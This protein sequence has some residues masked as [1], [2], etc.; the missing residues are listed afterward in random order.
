MGTMKLKCL[1]CGEE[2]AGFKLS[3]DHSCDS[4][5]RSQ[6]QKKCFEPGSDNSIFK[7]IDWLPIES[8]LET[9]IGPIV[10]KSEKFSKKLD[11]A[12]LYIAFNGYWPEKG[13]GNMTGTFKDFEALP[14]LIYFLENGKKSIILSSA[15]NTARAFAYAATLLDIDTYIVIPDR[16]LH[17]I[18][19]PSDADSNR[20]HII[21]LKES[22]DYYQ[23]I[24]LSNRISRELN[25]ESEGG[26]K[27][28]ARRDGLGTVILEAARVIDKLPDHYF[29]AVGSGTGGIAA[30]EAS[31]RLLQNEKFA[32]QKIPKLNLVQNAPFAPIYSAW[33]EGVKVQPEQNVEEQLLKIS[34]MY[35]DVLA[36]RNPIFYPRGGVYDVLNQTDGK[37]YAVNNQEAIEA[38]KEFEALE[39]VD[40]DPGAS[41]C[42]AALIK[43]VK[44]KIVRKDET[45]LLNITGGGFKKIKRDYHCNSIEPEVIID[46]CSNLKLETLIYKTI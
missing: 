6:Y 44:N 26:A 27:N 41:V 34:K 37:V 3:C 43:A 15:G 8:K 5:L 16:M 11:L 13:A 35:A 33:A 46:N 40:L 38:S 19:L 28:V 17:R 12:H 29:Q 20:I 39:G 21:A 25:I 24:M 7:F 45:I 9:S 22:C 36:N 2:Y 32:G 23:A 14:T 31:L 30:Y 42:T 1:E 18:W 10:F 4:L